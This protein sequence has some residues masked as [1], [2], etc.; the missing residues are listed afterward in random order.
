MMIAANEIPP[1]QK[2]ILSVDDRACPKVYRVVGK[3]RP[4]TKNGVVIVTG[5]Q[6][7]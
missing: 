6:E 5:V 4:K 3:K 1:Y 7:S 2:L